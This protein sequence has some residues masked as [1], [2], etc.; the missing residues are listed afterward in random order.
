MYLGLCFIVTLQNYFLIMTIYYEMFFWGVGAANQ[1]SQLWLSWSQQYNV[2]LLYR[3]YQIDFM[4]L[5]SK[6][7]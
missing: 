5:V 2:Y 3:K 6:Y 1:D 7:N 4:Y